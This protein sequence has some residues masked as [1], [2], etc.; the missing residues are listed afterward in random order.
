MTVIYRIVSEN[1]KLVY[2]PLISLIVGIDLIGIETE[3]VGTVLFDSPRV[4][5]KEP[6]LLTQ[7]YFT[8]VG[9]VEALVEGDFLCKP[10]RGREALGCFSVGKLYLCKD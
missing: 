3:S 1:L 7:A 4:S 8:E 6:S 5:Q 2:L 10:G 9:I